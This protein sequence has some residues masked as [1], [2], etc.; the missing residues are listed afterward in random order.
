MRKGKIVIMFAKDAPKGKKHFWVRY[1]GSNGRILA[2]TETFKT[3]RTAK[4][5]IISMAKIFCNGIELIPFMDFTL[6][7]YPKGKQGYI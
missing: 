1:V 3:K 4:G 6:K 7:D 2:G 5:N